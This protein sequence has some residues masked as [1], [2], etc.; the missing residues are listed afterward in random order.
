MLKKVVIALSL[1]GAFL[2]SGCVTQQK[3]QAEVGQA[4]SY[5]MLSGQLQS[6][7]NTAVAQLNTDQVQIQQLQDRLK[8]TMVN[9]LLFP[10]GGFQLSKQGEQ[11]LA[12][13]AP[14]LS[15]V[16][17]GNIIVQGYTDN[18]PI[19]PG[20][21]ERFPSNWELA[22]TRATDVVRYLAK[23]GVSASLLSGQSFGDTRP[24]ASN[25]TPEG[26]AK[27]RRVDITITGQ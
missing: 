12:K 2:L 7:L 19:G 20:L 6:E 3:Y 13:L 9:E 23:Q 4:Q 24:I 16:Q 21:R 11:V 25:D 22:G 15:K 1:S 17:N 8:V 14:A 26:R 5:Q 18:L 10:E 27:N